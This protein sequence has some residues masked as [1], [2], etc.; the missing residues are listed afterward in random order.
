MY[1]SPFDQVPKCYC[2]LHQLDRG[3]K[4][5]SQGGVTSGL[6]CIDSGV[7][8]LIRH[9]K[10]GVLVVNH[11]ATAGTT[12]AEASLFSPQYHC[13][14]I[15]TTDTAVTE[16]D[17]SYLLDQFQLNPQFSMALAQRFAQQIQKSRR[18]REILAIK[19][20]NERTLMAIHEG[21]LDS[22]LK[23]FAAEIGLTHEALYRALKALVQ[24]GRLNKV[25]RGEYC[26]SKVGSRK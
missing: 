9:T 20:A 7:I 21:M 24:Q 2:R 18:L 6:F 15:A 23:S 3:Q 17:R 12:F 1:P 4:L 5:F 26:L 25:A 10:E 16:F 19:S 11:R 8:E 22:N 14:A 13:D